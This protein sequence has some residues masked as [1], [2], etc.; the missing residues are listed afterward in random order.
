M[1]ESAVHR[2]SLRCGRAGSAAVVGCQIDIQPQ[3]GCCLGTFV[4]CA[5]HC[6]SILSVQ[7]NPTCFCSMPRNGV[8]AGAVAKAKV[9]GGG[10]GPQGGGQPRRSAAAGG[11][12]CAFE[13]AAN[14]SK[15]ASCPTFVLVR[16]HS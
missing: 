4:S 7:P 9:R 16:C 1:L 11:S 8:A 15:P 14:M 12:G 10:G 3:A 2:L 5:A 6:R 13:L